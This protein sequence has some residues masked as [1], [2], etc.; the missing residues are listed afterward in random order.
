L[1]KQS[2]VLKKTSNLFAPN[3]NK[4]YFSKVHVPYRDSQLTR[5]LQDSL[6]GNTKTALIATISP[7]IDHVEESISTMKFANRA[8]EVMTQVKVNEI[9]AKDDEAI[10]RLQKEVQSLRDIL[11]MRRK[12]GSVSEA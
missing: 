3:N 8:K 5:L 9:N 1:S 7:I 11:N 4:F 6:G 12:G 10:Q 2:M